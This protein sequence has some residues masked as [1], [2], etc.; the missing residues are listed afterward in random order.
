M[1]SIGTPELLILA[2]IMLL[3]FGAS[4]LPSLMRNM[5]RSVNEFKQGLRD[6]PA[7]PGSIEDKEKASQEK[8]L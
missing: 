6:E 2:A 5:G 4:R 3:L 7:S 8:A 1:P